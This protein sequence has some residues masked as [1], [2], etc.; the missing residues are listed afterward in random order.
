VVTDARSSDVQVELRYVEFRALGPLTVE[1]NGSPL[2][3]GGP[4]QRMVLAV[5]LSR[6]NH[7]VSQDALID[8]VWAGEPP[9]AAKSTLQS[10]VYGLRRELGADSILRQGDGYRVEADARSFDVLGFEALVE[11]GRQSL[12]TDPAV[13]RSALTRALGMWFGT[14]Y[15]GL[16]DIP[17]LAA[18]VNRL[19]EL[20][21]AA[22]EARIDADLESGNHGAV[23]G[24]LETLV[25]EHPLRERFRFQQMLALY[26]SGRQAEALR[27]F[28]QARSHLI[29]ELGI[30]PST[31]LRNLEQQIL[32]QDPDLQVE[33][34][35][36][37][38]HLT[39]LFTDVEGS[40]LLW[41]VDAQLASRAIDLQD[42]V[43]TRSVDAHG[44]SVFKRTGDGLYASFATHGQAVAAAVDAQIEL[45]A[46]AWGDTGPVR[47]RMA[48]AAGEVELRGGDFA[49]HVLH[50]AARILGMGHGGQVLLS[51]MVADVL[52]GGTDTR[53]LG[54][55]R[56]RGMGVPEKLY[57]LAV[58][59]LPDE[60]PPLRTDRPTP[61]VLGDSGS[62]TVRGYELRDPLG[63]GDFGVVYRAYQ[64]SV[65]REVAVKVIRPEY[66]N[67]LAFV[68]RFERE[69]Q[70]VAQLEHPHIL[71][72][73]D[74]WRDPEGAF[75]VMPIMRGGSLAEALRRGGWNLGPALQLLDQVGG[76]LAYAHRRGVIHRDVKTG[77][78]LLDEEGNAYLSDFGI[79]T[80]LTDH[81]DAPVTSSRAFVPPEEISGEQHTS[82]SDIFSLGVLAFQLLTGVIP[83]GELPIPLLN[84]IHPGIP[85]ALA[86]AVATATAEKPTDRFERVDD[87]LRAVRRAVGADV[88]AVAPAG[89]TP[90]EPL[91]NPYKGLR[92]FAEADAIDFHGRAALI[93]EL[94]KAVASHNLV[95]VVG[96]SGSGKSS[97]VR[98]GLIPALRAGGVPGS[99][100]WLL[101]EMFPGSYPF[102]ELEASL[103]RV[104]V[105]RPSALLTELLEPNGLLRVTK[106]I[107]PDEESTLVI[108]IDQFEEL[109]S[110]VRSEA[111]RRLFLDNLTAVAADERSRVRIVLTM[112]AD[113]FNRPL[114]YGDF[115]EVMGAG[116]VTVGI[117]TREGLA[118]AIA[119]PARAV[120]LEL[121]P[122]LVGR[123]VADVES[124]PGGL[125]LLQYALT[126]M[127]AR[128]Q[129]DTLTIA[130]YEQTGGVLGAL[131]RRAEEL[132]SG[133]SE[134]GQ[135]AARQVFLRLVSVDESA[136]DTR[137]RARQ[138]ELKS[139]DVD[140]EALDT[141]LHTYGGFRLLSFDRDP[142]TRGPTVEVAH[143][144]LI[145]EWARLRGWIDD[146][147]ETLILGRRLSTSTQEWIEADRDPS[148][149]LRGSRLE[150]ADQWMAATDVALTAEEVE[151]LRASTEQRESDLATTRRRRRRL[152]ILLSVGLVV[153]AS[154]AL[155]AVIQRGAAEREA[156]EARAR[157]LAGESI[158]AL[159]EDPELAILIALEA[160]DI[161]RQAGTLPLPEAVGALQRA[162]QTSRLVE[163]I[164]AGVHP[165]RGGH[166]LGVGPARDWLVTNGL[167]SANLI[168]IELSNRSRVTLIAPNQDLHATDVAVS[169]DG[170]K[171]AVAYTKVGG[172]LY[173]PAYP[174][175]PDVVLFDPSTGG[176]LGRIAIESGAYS[177]DF[178]PD[179]TRLAITSREY[180][181]IWDL[182]AGEP[183]VRLN[184]AL[185]ESILP[186]GSSFLEDGETIVVPVSGVGLVFYNVTT[187]EQ[188]DVMPVEEME[189]GIE[190][191]ASR[192]RM[193]F[194]AGGR[195]KIYETASP[196]EIRDM[197][198]ADP[199]ALA[200]SPSGSHLAFAGF[201]PTISVV[202][203]A[204]G[205]V[206]RSLSG[207][208]DNIFGLTFLD[209]RR[210]ANA[211]AGEVLIWD[212]S[213]QGPADLGAIR[214]HTGPPWG[215]TL[216]S[217]AGRLG[218]FIFD[219]L[220][221]ELI[222]ATTGAL[223]AQLPN[224]VVATNVGIRTTSPD[225]T[226]VGALDQGDQRSTVRRLPSLEVVMEFEHCRSPLAFSPDNT[227]VLVSGDLCLDE[228]TSA[229]PSVS[230]VIEISSGRTVLEI[231]HSRIFSAS[232]NPVGV[233][234][235]GRYL[236]LTD[237]AVVQIYDVVD[238]TLVAEMS[239]EGGV[240]LLAFDPQGQYLVGGS[241]GGRVWAVDMSAV[242]AD[243]SMADAIVFDRQLHAGVAAAPAITG[244]G[245]IGSATWD[246]VR[247]WDLHNDT[248][249]V[250]FRA[251]VD[252]PVVAF[253][254]D[255][256]YLMY[257][258]DG[259]LVR[260]YL[261]PERLIAIAEDRLT[262][263]F[264]PEECLRYREPEVCVADS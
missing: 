162:L 207:S 172:A 245:L 139:L 234:E 4:R 58:P 60:F 24:E 59:G 126:E 127:F 104:A 204:T 254:S 210:L 150:Q 197:G 191:D 232:F 252:T 215:Y 222:D 164:E 230:Q 202:D 54:E 1:V 3:L 214:P 165:S 74:F 200:W 264:T 244:D 148:F 80:R 115:A 184:L 63:S 213:P 13:A 236:A 34:G 239:R 88:V 256:S 17:V 5:L 171:V 253:S 192:S 83:S 216:N 6:A 248:P 25:R 220:S 180:V 114:E 206:V 185:N 188:V 209:E 258:H 70:I 190:V 233:H 118:Q 102:E 43:I 61:P 32:D 221:F 227:H 205:S 134:S 121:E 18:E 158:L 131:G 240:M 67:H 208:R 50:R 160:V 71:P 153:V 174:D 193:A 217:D 92:A 90:T 262:R 109:F 96:P 247:V 231:P 133:L 27:A 28:H 181:E 89:A 21:L 263:D 156:R 37:F 170:G 8:A 79:A 39:F 128:R 120:S 125:P 103:L 260:F 11:S 86:T 250:E 51:E 49:G 69:A 176:E 14:P 66:A 163:R 218:V 22:V 187:G 168:V 110:S 137:R 62:R 84:D 82:R 100:H 26:R 99:R 186:W 12:R 246:T 132:Y 107:L 177:L 20:R 219:S 40:T 113:F 135:G 151:Y 229:A 175:Y 136:A 52:D 257:P 48:I 224:Q 81:A 19:E 142:V 35:S 179:G 203:V 87:F 68:R 56:L 143:E 73:F 72:L 95:A 2:K 93:D 255:G 226:L 77:N 45:S 123:V 144:A 141:V 212:V 16:E 154:L 30:E 249:V 140:Q 76:A 159:D 124:Q 194:L 241:P 146:E 91:R 261:D 237:N 157:Q 235:A 98:A 55:Y 182:S 152:I 228:D 38:A 53:L 225:F 47:V 147:R 117:P 242:V 167:P 166:I 243:R 105:S 101:T 155:V 198:A 238:G 130:G 78:V 9:D 33:A 7:T 145:R 111:T 183:M 116:M 64:P 196:G 42:A 138:S 211:A 44:G 122:G 57:Q 189:P 41:D 65:G 169:S 46:T 259:N 36:A 149:L 29:E 223:L 161:S 10:Y 23:V 251:N 97:V 106:Q 108:V 129:D 173:Q 199:L 119:A 112:R 85:L 178:S 75:L 195:L 31:E 15:G 201:D 94:L